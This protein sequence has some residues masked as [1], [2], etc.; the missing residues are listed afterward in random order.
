MQLFTLCMH[1]TAI[2]AHWS[3]SCHNQAV[4]QGWCIQSHPSRTESVL[5]HNDCYD[6]HHLKP[7]VGGG[8]M[9]ASHLLFWWS[10]FWLAG[11]TRSNHWNWK[12]GS[13]LHANDKTP[14]P[15]NYTA[16]SKST[17]K[18]N[19]NVWGKKKKKLGNSKRISCR[20]WNGC[21]C[22]WPALS[23]KSGCACQMRFL[24]GF[25]RRICAN[26]ENLLE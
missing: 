14:F 1:T 13:L 26:L 15:N 3:I 11:T 25:S 2:N 8:E 16:L 10:H 19:P 12:S 18:W 21:Q 17:W 24:N 23:P 9:S 22:F 7:R 4:T 5:W 6:N 20:G